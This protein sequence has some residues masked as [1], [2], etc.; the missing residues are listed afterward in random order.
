VNGLEPLQVIADAN[1]HRQAGRDFPFVLRIDAKVRVRLLDL[2]GAE[3][4]CEPCRVVRAAQE[5]RQRRE[6][7]TPA[8]GPGKCDAVLVV[9]HVNARFERMRARLVRQVV[10]H[11]I[12]RVHPAGRTAGEPPECCDVGD[13]DGGSGQIARQRLQVAMRHLSARL[14]HSA[15]T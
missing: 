13:R 10:D 2:R 1:V 15:W 6:A 9:E 5:I 7:V 12:Q 14:E 11:L 3:G 8:Y 4:L